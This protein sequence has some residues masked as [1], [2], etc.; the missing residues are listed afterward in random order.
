LD[1][2]RSFLAVTLYFPASSTCKRI[3]N[4]VISVF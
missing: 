4:K 2:P 3:A 1:S